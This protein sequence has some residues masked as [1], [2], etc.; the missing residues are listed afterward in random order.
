MAKIDFETTQTQDDLLKAYAIK[1]LP[2]VQIDDVSIIIKNIII[3][4]INS[5]RS[6]RIRVR[7]DSMRISE[8]EEALDNYKEK[9]KG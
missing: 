3:G 5:M 4:V 8:V 1:N 6:E 7:L 9:I 2:N